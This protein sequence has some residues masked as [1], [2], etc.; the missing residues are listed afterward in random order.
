MEKPPKGPERMPSVTWFITAEEEKI[1]ADT[2][3]V[4][5]RD[6]DETWDTGI[7]MGSR[8]KVEG[9]QAYFAQVMSLDEKEK[10]GQRR[11]FDAVVKLAE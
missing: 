3:Q 2:G 8:V 9:A 1:L 5:L 11:K 7:K 6:R 10:K 4:M